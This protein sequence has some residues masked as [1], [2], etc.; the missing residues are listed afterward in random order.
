MNWKYILKNQITQGKQGVL[1]SDSPLPK[2]KNKRR[3]CKEQLIEWLKKAS[4]IET[5][6]KLT[7]PQ[8]YKNSGEFGLMP[9]STACRILDWFEKELKNVPVGYGKKQTTEIEGYT[10]IVSVPAIYYYTTVAGKTSEYFSMAVKIL[11]NWESILVIDFVAMES[12]LD[13]DI[14]SGTFEEWGRNN[15]DFTK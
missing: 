4:E 11:K 5:R 12:N 10:C 7:E 8:I 2:K 6:Y 14:S 1:T 3:E 9:E 13:K 15:L